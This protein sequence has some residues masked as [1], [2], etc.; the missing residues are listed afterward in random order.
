MKPTHTAPTTSFVDVPA[1]YLERT[2][3][4]YVPEHIYLDTASYNNR[5]IHGTFRAGHYP[6]TAPHFIHY[7]TASMMM[8]Y[9]SQLGY[10]YVRLALEGRVKTGDS[11]RLSSVDFFTLRD[12]GRIVIAGIEDLRFRKPIHTPCLLHLTLIIERV[13]RRRGG[14]IA[15]STFSAGDGAVHGKMQM[16]VDL[17]SSLAHAR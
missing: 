15:L 1:S 8:L 12:Q 2:L 4:I 17:A 10:V 6:F 13:L 9:L 7:V 5:S 3:E 16:A 11:N 14:I